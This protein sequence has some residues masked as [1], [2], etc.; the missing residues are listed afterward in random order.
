MPLERVAPNQRH[1]AEAKSAGRAGA[2][3][4]GFSDL[5]RATGQFTQHCVKVTDHVWGGAFLRAED[6][7]RPGWAEQWIGHV[8]DDGDAHAFDRTAAAMLD[9]DDI[10]HVA[11]AQRLGGGEGLTALEDD[12]QAAGLGAADAGVDGGAA[13]DA[14]DAMPHAHL[15]GGHEQ[16]ASTKRGG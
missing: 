4:L 2:G 9:E 11:S 16:F 10:G 13:A 3:G 14:K 8:A 7:R 6:G 1:H 15:G 12:G 5:S